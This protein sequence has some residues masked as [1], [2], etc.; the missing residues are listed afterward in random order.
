MNNL[1]GSI[2]AAIRDRANVTQGTIARTL[3]I[4]PA[5]LSEFE[6]NK[7]MVS[8]HATS[9]I[10]GVTEVANI[11]DKYKAPLAHLDIVDREQVVLAVNPNDDTQTTNAITLAVN[12]KDRDFQ[13]RLQSF[14]SEMGY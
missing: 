3:R 7:R 8:R 10:A 4:E 5:R 6:N 14:L 2:F 12:W 1:M 11:P 9:D 13:I